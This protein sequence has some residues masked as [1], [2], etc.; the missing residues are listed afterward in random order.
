MAAA[1]DGPPDLKRAR[2]VVG[3]SSRKN[4]HDTGA[5]N[6]QGLDQIPPRSAAAGAPGGLHPG[7]R[8]PSRILATAAHAPS[9]QP[10]AARQPHKGLMVEHRWT[11][12]QTSSVSALRISAVC[13]AAYF[14]ADSPQ[15]PG[16]P[17]A[18]HTRHACQGPKLETSLDCLTLAKLLLSKHNAACTIFLK[19]STKRC[20]MKN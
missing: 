1:E 12:I 15:T 13:F 17:P 18:H 4:R 6:L 8:W 14:V 2:R 3:L 16:H 19:A 5:A 20:L 9:P 7:H 10:M 11:R